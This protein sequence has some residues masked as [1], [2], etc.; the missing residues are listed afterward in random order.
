[1]NFHKFL[2]NDYISTTAFLVNTNQQG[3]SKRQNWTELLKEKK[4]MASE[5]KQIVSFKTKS[6]QN[7]KLYWI[8]ILFP[9]ANV[10]KM[11][12]YTNL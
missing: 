8:G 5:K 11:S 1:M 4:I 12:V 3:S 9:Q 6:Q 7:L 10:L 2:K